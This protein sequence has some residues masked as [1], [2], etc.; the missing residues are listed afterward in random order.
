MD[1]EMGICL[2]FNAS[3]C[4]LKPMNVTWFLKLQRLQMLFTFSGTIVIVWNVG[5]FLLEQLCEDLYPVLDNYIVA[6]PLCRIFIW[7]NVSL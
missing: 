6:F 7:N 4:L 1:I 5:N 3:L 2:L